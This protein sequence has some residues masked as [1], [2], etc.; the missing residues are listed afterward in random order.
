MKIPNGSKWLESD[1]SKRMA[2][3]AE[4][5]GADLGARVRRAGAAGH[6]RAADDAAPGCASRGPAG[7]AILSHALLVHSEVWNKVVILIRLQIVWRK[8]VWV[9]IGTKSESA[10]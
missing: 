9:P 4:V 5:P 7:A 10:E 1:K 8:V 6:G 2:G 3:G